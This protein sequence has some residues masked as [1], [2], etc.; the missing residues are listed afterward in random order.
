M[1]KTGKKE[2]FSPPLVVEP[3]PEELAAKEEKRLRE[4]WEAKQK[5]KINSIIPDM[6]AAIFER[7]IIILPYRASEAVKTIEAS[8]ERINLA[9]LNLSNSRYL[10]TKELSEAERN[11]RG[12]NFLG[13]FELMDA[14]FRVYVIEGLGGSGLSMDQFY[15][16]NERTRPNDR[17]F[18]MLYNPDIKFKNRL[19]LDFNCAIKKIRLRDTLSKIM[20]SPDVYLRSKVPEDMYDT[21]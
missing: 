14:E 6:N 13:G 19:Y 18:K 3:T 8:F 1:S 7:M 2:T 4:E 11:N 12:L 17:K 16:D 10:N 15:R 5:D 21:L 20:S 9:G